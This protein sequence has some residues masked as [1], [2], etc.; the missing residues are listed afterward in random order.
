MLTMIVVSTILR[1]YQ[2]LKSMRKAAALASSI[3]NKVSDFRGLAPS[4]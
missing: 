4:E 1:F 2:E 3:S